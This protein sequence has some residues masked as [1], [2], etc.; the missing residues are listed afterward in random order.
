MNGRK[1]SVTGWLR[2][3]D[4]LCVDFVFACV[5]FKFC[6]FLCVGGGLFRV[7]MMN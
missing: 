4:C 2:V 6:Y 7:V 5:T 3:V 1:A